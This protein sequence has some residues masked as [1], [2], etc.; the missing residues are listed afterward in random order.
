MQIPL[1]D[2]N[3]YNKNK[4]LFSKNLLNEYQKFGFC[5]FVNH[6]VKEK[7]ISDAISTSKSFF[8]LDETTKQ[9]YI[10]KGCGGARGYTPFGIERAKDSDFSDLKEFWHVGKDTDFVGLKNIWPKEIHQFQKTLQ[11]LYNQLEEVGKKVLQAIALSLSLKETFFNENILN[12]NSI[13]RPIHYPPVDDRDSFSVRA[14]QHEDIN[15]ITLLVGSEQKGL[16]V[17]SKK[18]EW[19]PINSIPGTIVVN[20]GDMLQ[21]L[22]NNVYPSTTHRVVNPSGKSRLTSRYSIPFFLHPNP[23][24]LIKTLQGCISEEN[25]DSY[26]NSITANDYLNERLKEIGLL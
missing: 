18:N 17:L 1:I 10:L 19:V 26:P 5:G 15:L 20:I 6:G 4:T 3:D 14:A 23:T 16:E 25:P 2:L 21:R 24:F 22:T 13:L 7:L 12:G 8:N 11:E 9:Q